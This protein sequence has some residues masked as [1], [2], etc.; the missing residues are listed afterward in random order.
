[1]TDATRV[2]LDPLEAQVV[3]PH[4][5][6]AVLWDRK[7]DTAH[8]P[9]HSIA[10]DITGQLGAGGVLQ[11]VFQHPVRV[12]HGPPTRVNVHPVGGE[13]LEQR[14]RATGQFVAVLAHV[15]RGD[16]QQWLVIFERIRPQ[17]AL[18]IKTRRSG[19]Q[20]AAVRRDST[21]GVTGLD[22][23]ERRQRPF[24]LL[25]LFC[26]N[27]SLGGGKLQGDHAGER[28]TY[29]FSHVLSPKIST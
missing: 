12:M 15:L 23:T 5:L 28:D 17:P 26:A 6:I 25:C 9:F 20:T 19:G 10:C 8:R 27:R 18:G 11:G 1:M 22:R 24:E 16:F 14:L 13:A 7:R 4:G 3:V 21:L 29:Y 2:G